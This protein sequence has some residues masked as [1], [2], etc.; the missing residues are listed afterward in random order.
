[1]SADGARRRAEAELERYLERYPAAEAATQ[2][3]RVLLGLLSE[4]PHAP[5]AVR[6]PR[7]VVERHLAD[8]LVA[9]DVPE[10]LRA[11]RIADLGSGAGIPGLVLAATLPE[12]EVSLV[13]SN[14]RKTGFVGRAIAAMGLA[15]ATAICARAEAWE[16][17]LGIH[18][19]VTA[20]ALARLDV[21]A[22]YAA[23]LLRRGGN[24]LVWGGEP[25]VESQQAATRAAALLGLEPPIVL[26]V[27]P[28]PG[29]S[30]RHLYLFSKVMDTPH[31]FPRRVGV[32][33]K[34]PLGASRSLSDRDAR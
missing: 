1:V 6:E 18:D 10:V 34:R 19:L 17:G 13:D 28:F 8:A 9:L 20:R 31:R 22:E 16:S 24:A 4:D 14:G 26:P 32:A 15:N 29:A 27:Q 7:D 11:R 2:P 3:L 25:H 12:S 23:P 5:T 21:V 30:R 33:S